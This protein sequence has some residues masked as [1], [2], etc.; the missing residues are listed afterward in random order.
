MVTRPPAVVHARGPA[1]AVAARAPIRLDSPAG[2]LRLDAALIGRVAARLAERQAVA[3]VA[4]P[5]STAG[6]LV[7]LRRDLDA[8]VLRLRDR[9][10]D[11]AACS[12]LDELH[13][14]LD[15]ELARQAPRLAARRTAGRVR[16]AQ[17]DLRLARWSTAPA[18]SRGEPPLS[19]AAPTPSGGE[20]RWRDVADELAAPFA[21][22][23]RLGRAAL[24][25]HLVGRWLQA[26]GDLDAPALLPLFAAG[27]ALA[28][29]TAP[30]DERAIVAQLVLARQLL[31]R[32]PPVVAVM[33]GLAGSG[34]STVAAA[35]AAALGAVWLRDEAVPLLPVAAARPA[36]P[37]LASPAPAWAG[38]PAPPPDLEADPRLR[39]A[40]LD[41]ARHLLAAGQSVVAD[42]CTLTHADRRAWLDLADGAGA[43][44]HIVECHAPLS[45]LRQRLEALEPATDAVAG[46]RPGAATVARL[47]WQ[48]YRV[49]P[50]NA[51][52]RA[53]ASAVSTEGGLDALMA[54]CAAVAARIRETAEP[55]EGTRPGW[56]PLPP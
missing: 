4:P 25:W 44:A 48:L 30:G 34:K 37:T 22:L 10:S 28:Q 26:S 24:A 36:T 3:A 33:T 20:P 1:R 51:A 16:R 42:S 54:T 8:L 29:A 12:V 5:A 11:P 38:D 50:L 14:E 32:R 35:L 6:R 43:A 41:A 2:W 9:L 39:P 53:R 56:R 18:K 27:H 23:H 49:E 52:E 31:A 55:E 15:I 17:G 13:R 46:G 47:A 21:D 19:H 40:M 45:S 7:V